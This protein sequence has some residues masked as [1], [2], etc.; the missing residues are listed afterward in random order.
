MAPA[1]RK[2]HQA[3]EKAHQPLVGA[4][5]VADDDRVE[6]RPG[7][8]LV[9]RF[10]AARR[11]DT[12]ADRGAAGRDPQ[13]GPARPVV[14]AKLLDAPAGLVGMTQRRG[15]LVRE[16]RLEQRLEQRYEA[17]QAVGQRPR[18]DRQAVAGEPCGDAVNGPE[19]G[20]VLEQEAR[21]EA[22]PVRRPAE[23]SRHRG[24][25]H[26]HGRGRTLAGPAQAR[27]A[28]HA[29]VGLDLDLDEGGFLGAVRRIGLPT[30]CADACIRRRVDLFGALLEP[31]PLGATVAGRPVLMAA[32]ASRTRFV[33]LLALTPVELLRQHGPGR[34]QLLEENRG[35]KPWLRGNPPRYSAEL[36]VGSGETA[37]I[38]IFL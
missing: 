1:E 9:R 23:Q 17:L 12:E 26:F 22:D 6:P 30:L 36:V 21:P 20:T 34:A 33:L 29:L 28:D 2:D 4:V 18:R 13:P 38:R 32:L 14:A 10:G 5:A 24:R 16:D 35:D 31:G 19:A 3:P 37:E 25:R 8:Q 27:A 7:E 15:V 11:V